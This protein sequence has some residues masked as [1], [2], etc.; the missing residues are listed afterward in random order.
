MHYIYACILSNKPCHE[1]KIGLA[2]YF[3]EGSR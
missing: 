1:A 2:I 3:Y